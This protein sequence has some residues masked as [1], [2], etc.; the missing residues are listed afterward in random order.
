MNEEGTKGKMK[1]GSEGDERKNVRWNMKAVNNEG[2]EGM[3]EE[4]DK[5]TEERVRKKKGGREEER[6]EVVS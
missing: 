1:E 4:K 6:E 2:S 3:K 5:R